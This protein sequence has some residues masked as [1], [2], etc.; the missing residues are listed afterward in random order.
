MK[1]SKIFMFV[2]TLFLATYTFAIPKGPC[3]SKKEI[4]C[5]KATPGPFAFAYPKDIGLSCPHDLTFYADFLWMQ[6][7]EDG[8]EYAITQTDGI[9][10]DF[11]LKGGDLVGYSTDDHSWDWNYGVR[12]GFSFLLD[13]DAWCINA[14]WTYIRIKEDSDSHL[15]S[16]AGVFLPFF[17]PPSLTLSG[18]NHLDVSQRWTGNYNSINIA[19]GKPYHISRYVIF[20]PFFGIRA[21]WVEQHKTSRYSGAFSTGSDLEE[22]GKNDFW[23]IGATAGVLSEWLL[24]AGWQLF[25]NLGASLLYSHFDVDQEVYAG[26]DVY[27]SIERDFYSNVPTMDIQ[28][29]IRWNYKF[30]KDQYRF[31]LKAA[32]EF[33][34]LW[35][36]NRFRRFVDPTAPSS[37]VDLG[38]RDLS[39]TGFSFGLL[40]DF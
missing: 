5:D 27:T 15:I 20:S 19:L 2:A 33:H 36:M 40:F 35:G 4:C 31:G 26:G 14:E 13:H 39:F 16:G 9:A 24:G 37:N 30:G 28:M 38:S 23:G 6:A 3:E 7:K 18:S 12:V 22:K 29:G 34:H 1:K 32:Y 8:L 17:L 25:G 11:P 21:T 10:N